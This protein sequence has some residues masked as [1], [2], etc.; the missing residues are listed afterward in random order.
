MTSNIPAEVAKRWKDL[1][2][3]LRKQY[4]EAL[5]KGEKAPIVAGFIDCFGDGVKRVCSRC[6]VEVVM[7]PWAAEF[8]EKYVLDIVCTSCA[9]I[10]LGTEEYYKEMGHRLVA[11]VQDIHNIREQKR[12]VV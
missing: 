9:L 2:D 12:G 7:R 10:E 3:V 11:G 1:D 5:E 8:S 4:A 6:G